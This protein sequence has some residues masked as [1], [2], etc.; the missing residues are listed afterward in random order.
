MS[1]KFTLGAGMLLTLSISGGGAS[2]LIAQ[3]TALPDHMLSASV[4]VRANV[5]WNLSRAM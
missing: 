4:R 2:S 5:G 3:S 1:W